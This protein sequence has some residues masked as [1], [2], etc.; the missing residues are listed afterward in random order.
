MTTSRVIKTIIA[1]DARLVSV[2]RRIGKAESKDIIDRYVATTNNLPKKPKLVH[3]P[4]IDEEKESV[5]IGFRQIY[6]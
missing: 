6:T 3:Y 1:N 2:H 4:V 5:R